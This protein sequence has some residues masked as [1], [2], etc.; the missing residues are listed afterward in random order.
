MFDEAVP[1]LIVGAG[2]VG[3]TAALLL[4]RQ[5][6]HSI[7]VER[8]VSTSIHPRAKVVNTRVMELFRLM[9]LED[10][11]RAAGTE[12][13]R[14]QYWLFVETLVG[15]EIRRVSRRDLFEVSPQVEQISP[16]SRA[17]CA[18]NQL[19][20][21]LV[22]EAEKSGCTLRF[23]TEL[24]SFEQDDSGVVAHLKEKPSGT[25]YTICADY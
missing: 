14:S 24:V 2:P 17:M 25:E 19:E 18:Q 4:A 7:L 13:T 23:N 11:I 16:T 8:H 22:E 9:G 21:L 3:L 20:P 15:R 6:V 10:R 12:L 5:G 1:V